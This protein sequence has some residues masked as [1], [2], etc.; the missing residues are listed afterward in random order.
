MVDILFNP[1]T[2]VSDEHSLNAPE[3]IEFIFCKSSTEFPKLI[4]VI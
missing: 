4:S 3:G 2:F 1:V